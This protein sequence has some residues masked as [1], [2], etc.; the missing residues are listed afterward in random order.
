ML[1]IVESYDKESLETAKLLIAEYAEFLGFDLNFQDFAE[2]MESFPGKYAP[3]GGCLLL[4][5][6][7]DRIAGCIALRKMDNDTCEM[8]RL[9]VRPE[10]R[11][12][13]AGRRLAEELLARAREI[14]YK[15]MRLDTVPQ[16][17]SAIA[18]YEIIGFYDIEPYYHNPVP[19]ARFMELEL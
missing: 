9:F 17:A 5:R 16:L 14:G 13:G 6:D 7:G 4:A 15:K 10:F 19:G 11:G 18:L 8:K 2:E 3:P 1:T 12:H